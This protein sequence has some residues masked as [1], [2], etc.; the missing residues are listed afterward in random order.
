MRWLFILPVF[1]LS[2][3]CKPAPTA[4]VS[5]SDGPRA[6]AVA[7]GQGMSMGN[8]VN[9]AYY[10]VMGDDE[11][12]ILEAMIDFHSSGDRLMG[13]A[14]ARFGA[15][16]MDLPIPGAKV[17]EMLQRPAE[18][19]VEGDHATLKESAGAVWLLT[20]D[21]ERWKIDLRRM[22]AGG[23]LKARVPR[24]VAAAA[25]NQTLTADLESGKL[26][27]IA[28]LGRALARAATTLPKE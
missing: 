6:A 11:E 28:D 14:S 2:L 21:D 13:A 17:V 18:L 26:A 4:T 19:K 1:G 9:S 27:T 23:A 12:P 7:F 5:E 24:Y 3:S 16:A 10:A 25:S 15:G 22:N 20:R 8:P